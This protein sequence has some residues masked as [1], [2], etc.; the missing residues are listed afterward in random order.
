MIMEQLNPNSIQIQ[1]NKHKVNFNSARTKTEHDV[2]T[3]KFLPTNSDTVLGNRYRY[4]EII[5]HGTFSVVIAAKDLYMHNKIIAIKIFH[6]NY[7]V[8]GLQEAECVRKLNQMDCM[9]VSKVIKIFNTIMYEDHLCIVYQCLDPRPITAYFQRVTVNENHEEKLKLLRHV[10]KQLLE[11]LAFLRRANIIHADIKPANILV[12]NESDLSIKLV[13]FSNSFHCVHE[14]ICLYYDNFELQTLNYRAPELYSCK[15]LFKGKYKGEIIQNISNL[16]GSWPVSFF[17]RGKFYQEFANEVIEHPKNTYCERYSVSEVVQHPFMLAENSVNYFLFN[18][19]LSGS[20]VVPSGTYQYKPDNSKNNLRLPVKQ[21]KMT[22]CTR[23]RPETSDSSNVKSIGTEF[24]SIN[25]KVFCLQ[26]TTSNC[27]SGESEKTAAITSNNELD[28]VNVGDT[29]DDEI[30]DSVQNVHAA[31]PN[32]KDYVEIYDNCAR[33]R[34]SF[35]LRSS[36]EDNTTIN[37]TLNTHEKSVA[38]RN[39][40]CARTRIITVNTTIAS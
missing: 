10:V 12:S 19:D 40:S 22:K 38:N 17:R 24:S 36:S 1:A 29:S 23:K 28:L 25:V 7:K 26:R 35:W 15:P 16:L 21:D 6:R 32:H 39:N 4:K 18:D 37:E 14:E 20:G 3:N 11:C 33:S 30:T 9:D 8:I 27:N 34:G 31:V 13:D 2:A 5:G